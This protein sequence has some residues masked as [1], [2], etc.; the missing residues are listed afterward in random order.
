MADG[1]TSASLA[2][3]KVFLGHLPQEK[4]A[5]FDDDPERLGST[6][7]SKCRAAR[8]AHPSFAVPEEEFVAAMAERCG[9]G[10]ILPEE[11]FAADLYL[12]VACLRGDHEAQNHFERR[13]LTQLHSLLRRDAGTTHADEAL[14]RLRI[15]LFMPTE[16]RPPKAAIYTGKVPL[17]GWLTIV[18]KRELSTYLRTVRRNEVEHPHDKDDPSDSNEDF[19]PVRAALTSGAEVDYFRHVND[20]AVR[21]ALAKAYAGLASDERALLKW[22]VKEGATVDVLGPRLGV[23]R[24]TAARM[25]ARTKARI[26]AAVR[27][28]LRA[29]LGASESSLDSICASTAGR[30]DV[31]LNGIID[32]NDR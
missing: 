9:R 12:C 28:E 20:D 18:A 14:Q 11:I 5:D 8:E 23:H 26:L 22:L 30:L 10:D 17:W 24:A 7:A 1:T 29:R 2:L 15:A 3:A 32:R 19:E 4:R 21:N 6:L 31:T 27:E 16:R 13:I 25:I